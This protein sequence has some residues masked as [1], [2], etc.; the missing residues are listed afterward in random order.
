[1][2]EPADH[3]EIRNLLN[4][5]PFIVD[6]PANYGRAREVFTEDAVF[7]GG[8]YGRFEGVEALIDYWSH[9]PKRA[10]ALEKSRLL[11]HNMVNIYIWQDAAGV[12]R[13]MSRCIGTS[14]DGVASIAVYD[15]EL[16]RTPEGW[17]ISYRLLSA[18]TPPTVR[19]RED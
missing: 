12:V 16:R 9:S 5:Y 17:R 13:S 19:I 1:M 18:M 14:L 10:A 3:V 4:L 11:S 2:L 15:D 7:D 6:I 8:D